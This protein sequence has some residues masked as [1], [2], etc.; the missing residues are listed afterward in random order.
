M[1]DN[2]QPEN[3]RQGETLAEAKPAESNREMARA[4]L[5]SGESRESVR[6]HLAKLR[7]AELL[8]LMHDAAVMDA[9]PFWREIALRR[10][11]RERGTT[12]GR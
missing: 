8:R 6:N 11:I 10:Y 5:A 7:D 9:S 12:D 1:P 3:A 4:I 2:P